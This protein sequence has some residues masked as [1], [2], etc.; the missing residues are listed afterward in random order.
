MADCRRNQA[1]SAREASRAVTAIRIIQLQFGH[2]VAPFLRSP[3][4]L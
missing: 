3:E 1:A 4:T 2:L